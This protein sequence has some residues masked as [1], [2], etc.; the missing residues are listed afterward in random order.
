MVWEVLLEVL[1]L[2]VREAV[3][4]LRWVLLRVCPQQ[5]HL[6]HHFHQL[7]FRVKGR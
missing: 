7:L 4:V 2:V 6:S 3:L 5:A 1:V